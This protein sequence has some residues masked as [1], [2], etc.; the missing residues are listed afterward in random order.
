MKKAITAAILIL[1]CSC[2]QQKKPVY[3]DNMTAREYVDNNI[4][5]DADLEKTEAEISSDSTVK[6]RNY[7][8][9]ARVRAATYRFLKTLT[10]TPAGIKTTA[11]TASDL[12]VS[13]RTF[14]QLTD[15]LKEMNEFILRQDSA[16]ARMS[17]TVQLPDSAEL[18]QLLK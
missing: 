15:N 4:Y 8:E 1:L 3:D 7:G 5:I 6:N 2:G 12:N 17:A 18:E 10:I 11:K 16:A 14:R 13:E 9:M